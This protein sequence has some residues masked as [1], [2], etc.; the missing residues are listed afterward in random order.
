MKLEVNSEAYCS[1][2]TYIALC[3]ALI[4]EIEPTW[5]FL[6]LVLSQQGLSLTWTPARSL[7]PLTVLKQPRQKWEISKC[8]SLADTTIK[9][10]QLESERPWRAGGDGRVGRGVLYIVT[11][12]ISTHHIMSI[13]SLCWIFP[14]SASQQIVC[15][16]P[17]SSELK[18]TGNHIGVSIRGQQGRTITGTWF[19][20]LAVLYYADYIFRKQREMICI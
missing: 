16:S 7:K 18:A 13:H 19:K 14:D 9:R 4:S 15:P 5:T 20:F 8:Q 6:R 17:C 3:G 1:F 10:S 11:L 12:W 2:Y